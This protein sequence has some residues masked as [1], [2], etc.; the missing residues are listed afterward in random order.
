MAS[1]ADSSNT[2]GIIFSSEKNDDD[3]LGASFVEPKPVATGNIAQENHVPM[4]LTLNVGGCHFRVRRSTLEDAH[5]FKPYLDGRFSWTPEKDGSYFVDADADIF[6]HVLRYLR[7]PQVYPLFWTKADGF[8]YD[9]YNH[10][11]AAAVYFQ[12]KNLELWI[13]EKHYLKAVSMQTTLT[14][15]T[16]RP[17]DVSE[18]VER[19]GGNVDIERSVFER[20]ERVCGKGCERYRTLE[21]TEIEYEEEFHLAVITTQKKIVV[22]EKVCF[23]RI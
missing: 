13:K 5:Y 10:L 22:D 11:E 18:Y 19:L 16:C 9:L 23:H 12:I 7:L 15:I 3:K 8:D 4:I 2:R 21:G 6:E 17:D 1:E 20:I 14:Y